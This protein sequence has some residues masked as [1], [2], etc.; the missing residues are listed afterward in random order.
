MKTTYTLKTR[1]TTFPNSFQRKTLVWREVT[2]IAYEV[3]NDRGEWEP[4]EEYIAVEERHY[5]NC[6]D[7]Y[8]EDGINV[9]FPY[10]GTGG[11][12]PG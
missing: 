11:S 6:E 7:M 9:L 12:Y 1:I 4:M 8:H 3:L 10:G 2:T 5:L